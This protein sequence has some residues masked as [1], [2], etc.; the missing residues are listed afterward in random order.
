MS[1]GGHRGADAQQALE[2]QGR[3]AQEGGPETES[4]GRQRLFVGVPCP[5]ELLPVVSRAQESLEGLPGLRPTRREQL[6]VTLAFLGE[7]DPAAAGIAREVVR[8]CAEERA[9][10]ATVTGLLP[11]PSAGRARVVTLKIDDV[12]QVFGRLFERVMSQLEANQ[13]MQR[14]KRPFRPHLTIARLRSP[15]RVE[16]RFEGAD[17]PYPVDSVNLYRSELRRE[18]ARYTVVERAPLIGNERT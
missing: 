2:Q 11:L 4:P 13:V 5:E 1:E 3:V 9:G 14:E 10:E 6:H 18:G 15:V 8:G 12:E 17:A 16:P 7:V